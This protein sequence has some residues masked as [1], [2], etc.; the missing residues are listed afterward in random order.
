[1]RKIE[2]I[3]MVTHRYDFINLFPCLASVKYWYPD[4][5]IVIIK[6]L[7]N[8]DFNLDFLKQ[9][10]KVSFMY[11]SAYS[12]GKFYGSLEPFISGRDERFMI[13]DTDTALTGRII[14]FAQTKGED[15]V[16]DYEEQPAEKIKNL[17]WDQELAGQYITCY[18]DLWFTFNN[19]IMVGT[20]NKITV[21]DFMDFM[22]WEKHK[23]PVIRNSEAFPTY[24]QSAINVVI[25]KKFVK[26]E[27]TVTRQQIMIYPPQFSGSE[28]ALLT[29][30]KQ[31]D[32]PEY[33]VIHWADT[34]YL[35]GK[36]KPLHHIFD[37]Y[38]RCFFNTLNP[39]H[40]A[41][42]RVYI[43]YLQQ[44]FVI[45]N[46]LQLRVKKIKNIISK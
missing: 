34:K 31:K 7:N 15:F 25:N 9:H 27:I 21:P 17:Y 30:I 12:Y 36:K 11:E 6:N 29:G 37:F 41:R 5:E 35:S 43:K 18:S 23:E 39:F 3:Y 38:T 44:E 28:S 16:I 26:K 20:G 10:Y 14:D 33:R 8:G 46:W 32:Q 24:D 22:I 45:K 19:G 40:A 42:L 2:R 1:M 4:T 13:L